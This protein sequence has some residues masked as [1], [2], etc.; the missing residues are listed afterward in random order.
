MEMEEKI[1]RPDAGIVSILEATS[2]FSKNR[3]KSLLLQ[4]AAGDH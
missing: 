2:P 4:K 3:R 1:R